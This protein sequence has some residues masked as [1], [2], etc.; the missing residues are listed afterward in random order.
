MVTNHLL[1]VMGWFFQS[2]NKVDNASHD[3]KGTLQ[4]KKL[5][6]DERY[7]Y[8]LIYHKSHLNV[9][10]YTIHGSYGI[11]LMATRNPVITHQLGLVVE[12]PLFTTGFSTIPG[13]GGVSPDFWTINSMIGTLGRKYLDIFGP[14]SKESGF[15][16]PY[17][18]TLRNKTIQQDFKTS[19]CEFPMIISKKL[20][21]KNKT[22]PNPRIML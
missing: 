19:I 14:D 15:R 6:W 21:A 11:L 1:Q 4:F 20:K 18:F 7:I 13:P 17:Y 3:T 9:G 2:N 22:N 12:I 10:R 5:A 16:K 8:L